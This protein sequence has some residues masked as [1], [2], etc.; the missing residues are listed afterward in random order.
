MNWAAA[1]KKRPLRLP[2]TMVPS[3]GCSF[4]EVIFRAKEHTFLCRALRD[5]EP[6]P[7]RAQ[8]QL[9]PVPEMSNPFNC[10]PHD[11]GYVG[12]EPSQ[13]SCGCDHPISVCADLWTLKQV[14]DASFK[15]TETA[16]WKAVILTRVWTYM[17]RSRKW[18]N[19]R[20]SLP[21]RVLGKI[22]GKWADPGGSAQVGFVLLFWE[23]QIAQS[24]K[25]Q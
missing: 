1:E 14:R 16:Q 11:S 21:S 13:G 17:G 22:P 2:V 3:D 5:H 25:E 15:A 7:H 23:V 4:P 24:N 12:S 8:S 18:Q 20:P 9:K 6:S 19:H 10:S